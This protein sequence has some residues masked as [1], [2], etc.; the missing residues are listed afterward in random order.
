MHEAHPSHP[1][2]CR[3]LRRHPDRLQAAFR[4]LRLGLRLADEEYRGGELRVAHVEPDGDPEYTQAVPHRGL[5]WGWL[6]V[7]AALFELR[8]AL[9]NRGRRWATWCAVAASVAF[10][11][12]A[13]VIDAGEA[14]IGWNLAFFLPAGGVVL[15]VLI[16]LGR[17]IWSRIAAWFAPAVT[18][19]DGPAV[20]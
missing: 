20:R 4:L 10:L 5:F 8:A 7:V 12:Y 17:W 16:A 11:L 2:L 19:R 6:L 15:T 1:S 14:R 3:A 9:L 18:T 13:V